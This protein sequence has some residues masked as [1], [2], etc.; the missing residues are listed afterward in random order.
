M[1]RRPSIKKVAITIETISVFPYSHS[2]YMLIRLYDRNKNGSL[3]TLLYKENDSRKIQASHIDL[4]DSIISAST[5]L[6]NFLKAMESFQ[7]FDE[8]IRH[9][10]SRG[11]SVETYVDTSVCHVISRTSERAKLPSARKGFQKNRPTFLFSDRCT[12]LTC[13]KS[14]SQNF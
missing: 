2:N 13:L 7:C 9:S 11:Q 6:L 3:Q 14:Y 1:N 10:S 8:I 12:V 5:L 4:Q